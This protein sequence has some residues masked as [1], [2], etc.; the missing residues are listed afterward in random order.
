MK[1]HSFKKKLP[2]YLCLGLRHVGHQI[3][4]LGTEFE[5]NKQKEKEG[6]FP[7]F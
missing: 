2:E 5:E 7:I 4:I 6:A 1:K 3:T